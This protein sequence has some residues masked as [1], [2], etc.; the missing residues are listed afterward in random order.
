MT[1]KEQFMK[2]FNESVERDGLVD[3]K[4]FVDEAHEL[5]E[6]EFYAAANE[7]DEAA[8]NGIEVD[9]AELERGQQRP[10]YLLS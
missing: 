5:S 2:R 6:E 7:F 8:A 4:F 3:M 9:L 10:S 1:A